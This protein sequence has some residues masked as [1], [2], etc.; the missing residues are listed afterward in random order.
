MGWLF[1]IQ[2][3]Q[4][5]FAVGALLKMEEL[6]EIELVW[7]TELGSV[8]QN[9]QGF[10]LFWP[11]LLSCIQ[12]AWLVQKTGVFSLLQI[13]ISCQGSDF[14]HPDLVL[15][16]LGRVL[17]VYLS[18]CGMHQMRLYRMIIW[19]QICLYCWQKI[20]WMLSARTLLYWEN[21]ERGVGCVMESAS[22]FNISRK[23]QKKNQQNVEY[24]I[25]RTRGYSFMS[26]KGIQMGNR[27]H[28][29]PFG[30]NNN[31]E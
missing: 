29:R 7:S 5:Y 3:A 28:D 20:L 24:Q 16:V 15:S 4:C 12:P 30:R 1:N 10:K 27:Y 21:E 2:S 23:G 6:C 13:W 25:A 22:T 19:T 17:S 26:S 18:V 8:W 9:L 11:M 14:E 31:K